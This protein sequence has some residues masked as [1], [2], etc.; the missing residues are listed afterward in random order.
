MAN[1]KYETFEEARRDLG[2]EPHIGDIYGSPE[3]IKARIT[4]FFEA[5]HARADSGW[6]PLMVIFTKTD[7]LRMIDFVEMFDV[8]V[9]TLFRSLLE[10]IES[11]RKQEG[12]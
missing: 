6:F 3:E 2:R 9:E 12:H 11:K 10:A 8:D 5:L 4:E 1:K 7:N